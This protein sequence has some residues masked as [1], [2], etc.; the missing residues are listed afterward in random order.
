MPAKSVTYN[1]QNYAGTLG[2]GLL[3]V[4]YCIAMSTTYSLV[5]ATGAFQ[6]LCS[7]ECTHAS[8]LKQR[9]IP[10]S[11]NLFAPMTSFCWHLPFAKLKLAISKG[12]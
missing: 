1:S 6:R 4:Y 2:S 8:T 5:I 11:D 9:A 10:D 7:D 12:T 3:H